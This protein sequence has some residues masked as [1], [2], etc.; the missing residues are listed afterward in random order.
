MAAATAAVAVAVAV[1]A[2][3]VSKKTLTDESH[4]QTPA[5]IAAAKLRDEALPAC[6]SGRW[7]LCQDKLD[8]A[9]KLDPAS[10]ADARVERMREDIRL[11]TAPAPSAPG[12]R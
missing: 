8:Q 11:H 3:V 9:A 6:A 5:Q 10:E 2:I 1:V 4:E 7:P 12:A